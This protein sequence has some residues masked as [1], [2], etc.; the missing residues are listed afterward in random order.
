MNPF[1]S[2]IIATY[3]R[4][5]FLTR[6]L[7]SLLAQTESGWEAWIIDDGSTDQTEAIIRDYIRDHPNIQYHKIPKSGEAAAKNM[8]ISLSTGKYITFLDSDDAYDPGHLAHRKT[9]LA[10]SP[11]IQLLHGGMKIIGDPYVPDR[12]NPE[13][14]IHVSSCVAGA[15]FVIRRDAFDVLHG[16]RDLPFGNDADLYERAVQSNLNILKTDNPTYIYFRNH[17]DSITRN[18]VKK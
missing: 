16:F 12:N 15:T 6:A 1:F 13:N 3:N 7:N 11:G 5:G 18:A 17:D 9:V 8:G 2:V 10:E 4:A 14:L